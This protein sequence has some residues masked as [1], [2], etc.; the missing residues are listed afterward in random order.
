MRPSNWVCRQAQP[1]P[2]ENID[3]SSCLWLP[4]EGRVPHISLVFREMWDT[5]NVD[6]SMH[7]MNRESKGSSIGI[8]HL[9]KNERDVGH[10]A[11]VREPAVLT[12]HFAVQ[13]GFNSGSI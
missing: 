12:Q 3:L 4:D 2:R 1:R 6:R 8:P 13:P 9:A 11:F 10:P 7:R 5:T